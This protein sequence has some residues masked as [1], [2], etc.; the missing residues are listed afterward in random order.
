VISSTTETATT[1]DGLEQLRRRWVPG[2]DARAAMLLVHGIGEHS[3]RYEHVGAAFAAAGLDVLAFDQRGFGESG[4]RRGHVDDF[5]DFLNDVKALIDDRRTLE[6]PV[7]LLGHSLGGLISATYLVSDRPQPDLAVL[8]APALA[9]ELPRWQRIA[10]PV[11]GSIAPSLSIPADF[12]GGLL[13]RDEA[14]QVAYETDPLRVPSS[15]ARLGREILSAMRSTG[16]ALD[17][18]NIP[19]YVLH[20]S[21]DALVPPSASEPLAL[22]HNVTRREWSGLRHECF[23]E[24]EQDDVIADVVAWLHTQLDD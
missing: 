7:I 15:T 22:L 11:L 23:N 19:T 12:D 16:E 10:A 2:G 6:L 20:G 5:D 24:P 9:A 8:S 4:G 18:I 17:R 3:G 14:V 21:D 1:F 13:S